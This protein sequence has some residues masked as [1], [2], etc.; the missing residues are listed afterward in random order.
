MA[1][2][3]LIPTDLSV[4]SLNTLK[5]ALDRST[6]VP[7]NVVLLFPYIAPTG[8]TELLFHSPAKALRALRTSE[9]DEALEVLRNRYEHKVVGLR[10]EMIQGRTVGAFEDLARQYGVDEVHL[11]EPHVRLRHPQAFDLLPSILGSALPKHVHN[12]EPAP[13]HVKED[14]LQ[15]LFQR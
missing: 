4:A 1:R 8:I 12:W 5:F 10:V 6:A 14:R 7:L 15:I 11:P 9:F 13:V 2:T 3:I